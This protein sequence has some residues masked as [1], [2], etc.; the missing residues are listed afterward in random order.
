MASTYH[1]LGIV[2]QLRGDLDAAEGWYRRALAIQE[3]LGDRPSMAKTYHNLGNVAYL[4]GDLDAAEGWYRRALAIQEEL[5]ERHGVGRNYGRLAGIA[6]A[7]GDQVTSARLWISAFVAFVSLQSAGAKADAGVALNA[8][9]DLAKA[10][11]IGVVETAWREVTGE[12]LP[13]EVR[14]PIEERLQEQPDDP[15]G[16]T[17]PPA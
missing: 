17:E 16:P 3:E 1:Q 4:R 13:A 12:E 8:L 14:A 2:A 6:A 5:G 11:G 15:K 9:A 7:R 10:Q